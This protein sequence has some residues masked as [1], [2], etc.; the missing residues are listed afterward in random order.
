MSSENV[1]VWVRQP[2]EPEVIKELNKHSG[3]YTVIKRCADAADARATIQSGTSRILIADADAHGLDAQFL[4]DMNAAE[5]F[6]LLLVEN[7]L[8]T[9]NRGESAVC[10]YGNPADIIETLTLGIKEKLFGILTPIEHPETQNEAPLDG[11]VIAFWGTH[12]APGRSTI[13]L[14]FGY[15]WSSE[16]QPVTIIDADL[17]APSLL[18]LAGEAPGGAG[19]AAALGLRNRGELTVQNLSEMMLP[20]SDNCQLLPGLTRAD[21]WRQVT[22]EGILELI[23]IQKKQANLVLDLGAGIGDTDPAQLSFVPSK[24]DIN[25]RLLQEADVVILIAKADAVGLTRLGYILDDCAENDIQ[26]DMI[27]INRAKISGKDR[28]LKQSIHRVLN[29]IAA[30]IPFLML[31]ETSELEEAVLKAQPLVQLAPHNKFV[32][33]LDSLKDYLENTLLSKTV[34]Q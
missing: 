29:T 19:L 32:Q 13:A 12:G 33:A 7:A 15:Q 24:E 1:V 14:N 5:V 23:E 18:Q 2:Y 16:K 28:K 25:L 21:R 27:L 22:S 3:K 30:N 11:K 9:R 17:Q 34:A 26:I 10:E 6:T 8:T 31:E 4:D 20:I